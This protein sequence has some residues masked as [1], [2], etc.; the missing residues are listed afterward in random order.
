MS[1]CMSV[2]PP[3]FSEVLRPTA[4]KLGEG[5]RLGQGKTGA[6]EDQVTANWGPDEK[7]KFMDV[8]GQP[9]VW[10]EAVRQLGVKTVSG[11]LDNPYFEH[12]SRSHGHAC[13]VIVLACVV[14]L[15]V[16]AWTQ[17]IGCNCIAIEDT[18]T[19]QTRTHNRWMMSPVLH[20]LSHMRL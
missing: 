10:N 3:I 1:V 7:H 12:C 9:Q 8:H 13:G 4:A 18:V 6:G 15:I 5:V 14:W 19:L 11:R 16:L 17:T 2:C 20:P